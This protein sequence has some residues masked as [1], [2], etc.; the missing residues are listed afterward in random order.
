M[1]NLK[2]KIFDNYCWRKS[3]EKRKDWRMQ[4]L[5][6]FCGRYTTTTNRLEV[7]RILWIY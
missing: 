4:K 3:A 6:R 7:Y 1:K 5:K 2:F